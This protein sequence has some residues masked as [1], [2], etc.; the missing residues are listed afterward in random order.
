MHQDIA[1]MGPVDYLIVEFPG[2]RMTGEGLPLLVD[3]V[4]LGQTQRDLVGPVEP[5]RVVLA[6]AGR[7]EAAGGQLD[8]RR[9]AQT[10]EDR[11]A[12]GAVAAVGR[13]E[14]RAGELAAAGC[15]PTTDNRGTADYKRHLADE[16]TRRTLRTAVQRIE[17]GLAGDRAN[18]GGMG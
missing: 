18:Q 9:V 17:A 14:D 10:A 1:D 12:V 16:L 3:L 11:D 4:D 8:H 15:S 13:Q 5:D 2:S 7:F 6:V